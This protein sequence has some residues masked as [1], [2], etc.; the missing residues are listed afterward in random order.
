M[1]APAPGKE[2][3][4]GLQQAGDDGFASSSLGIAVMD[5]VTEVIRLQQGYPLPL[6]ASAEKAQG[7]Q[8]DA[9]WL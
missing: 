4:Q 7:L 5:G 3:R 8:D 2:I 1:F 9:V 6:Y